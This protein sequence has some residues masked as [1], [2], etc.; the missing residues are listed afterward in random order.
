MNEKVYRYAS[1]VIAT[2]GFVM[3]ASKSHWAEAG[4]KSLN[5]A[6]IPFFIKYFLHLHF[7][8]YPQ[9]PL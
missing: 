5:C 8:Y 6:F 1:M 4:I 2:P 3:L 9:R 7:K